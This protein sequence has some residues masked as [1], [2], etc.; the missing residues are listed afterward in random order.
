MSG[1]D[2]RTR[3]GLEVATQSLVAQLATLR[4]VFLADLE[5]AQLQLLQDEAAKLLD[6]IAARRRARGS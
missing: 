5:P 3:R 1:A 4:V 2:E 6:A